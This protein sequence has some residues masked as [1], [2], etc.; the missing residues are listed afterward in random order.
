[1]L[2]T[3]SGAPQAAL[4]QVVE[5]PLEEKDIAPFHLEKTEAL[6]E[7]LTLHLEKT[8]P[9]TRLARQTVVSPEVLDNL[10]VLGYVGGQDAAPCPNPRSLTLYS[11]RSTRMRP[12][13][14]R[15][16]QGM[17]TTDEHR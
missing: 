10:R 5:D 13:F 17:G 15:N 1:M 6:M 7:L 2:D 16:P 9:L 11:K 14:T 8:P 12:D 3:T 4:H